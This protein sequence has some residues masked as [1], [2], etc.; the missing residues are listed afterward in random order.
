MA[1]SWYGTDWEQLPELELL[2]QGQLR[3]GALVFDLGAHQATVAS[4]LAKVGRLLVRKKRFWPFL[5]FLLRFTPEP[6]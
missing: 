6:A 3:Q 4:V 5:I 2:A 1:R